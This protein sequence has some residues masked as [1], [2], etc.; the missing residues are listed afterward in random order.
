MRDKHLQI[1]E[2]SRLLKEIQEEVGRRLRFDRNTFTALLTVKFAIYFSLTVILYLSLYRTQSPQ[3]FIACYIVYGFVSLLFAFNFSHDFSHSTVF[4]SKRWN[5]RCFTFIYSLVGA[6][7]EAWKQR[8][9]H[10]HHFA[11][12][13]EHYD[14]DM[15]ISG[16]IRVIPGSMY[17]WYH[18]FQHLYAPLAY[19]TYSLFWIFIKDFVILFSREDDTGYGTSKNFRYHVSFWLQ[20]CFYMAMILLLP[21][22]FSGQSWHTILI[23]FILMHM[24]QSLF[25]LFT[26]F[27]THHVETTAYPGIDQNGM[28]RSSWLMNQVKSSN[29]MHPFSKTANFI[30]GGFN[31]HVAHHLFPHIHH[32]YYPELSRILYDILSRNGITPNQT[33]YVGG[34]ISHMRLLKRMGQRE[35]A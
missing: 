16:L 24:F 25:L 9:I 11:P 5:M 27:M 8:H 7:A 12:N 21:L 35:R 29:D 32:I 10:S 20:K 3:S 30:L 14:S 31:N 23:G 17:K 4:K 6:H 34:I 28:I 15:K 33:S 18:R 13:V 19:T 2:D 1:D 26:F 22:F